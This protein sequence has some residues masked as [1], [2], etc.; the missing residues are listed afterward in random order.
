MHSHVVLPRV[1]QNSPFGARLRDVLI[2]LH[3]SVG[4]IVVLVELGGSILDEILAI[5]EDD[6][7]PSSGNVSETDVHACEVTPDDQIHP[8][9][10]L[11]EFH[12]L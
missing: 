5:G 10:D 7:D 1:H 8:V 9:R 6:T 11:G 4:E 12:V 3:L 2:L